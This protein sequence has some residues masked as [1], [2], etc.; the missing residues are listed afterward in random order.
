M[1][2]KYP[3]QNL[4]LNDIKGEKWKDIPEFTD[5]YQ[6]SNFGRVRALER[7]V[8][9]SVKGDML[10]KEL[11]LKQSINKSL[12]PYTG[13]FNKSLAV[14]LCRNA[15]KTAV[16][17]SRMVYYLF[18]RKFNL[19]DPTLVIISK[20][21]DN[22]NMNYKNLT[23]VQKG[24]V[25]LKTY[26]E[27]RKKRLFKPVSQYNTDGSLIKTYISL[28]SAAEQTG[29]VANYIS[30]VA[31]GNISHYSGMLWKYGSRKKIKA[32]KFPYRHVKRIAQYTPQGKL[33]RTFFS[34]SEAER[35]TGFDDIGI[36]DTAKKK[37]DTYKG[38]VWKYM[39]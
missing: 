5:Y 12:N 18:V 25:Q 6:L 35:I 20:D 3:Y 23:L 28:V 4:S 26:R 15:K 22:L 11:I 27:K 24:D 33:I 1:N 7:W 36:R 17:M 10:L 38:F 31:N 29:Y 39:D 30:Q 14:S 37:R 8:E 13:K 21:G 2:Y 34:I 19:D 32:V 9:R 16:V